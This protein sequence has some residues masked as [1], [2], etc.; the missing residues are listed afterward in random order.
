MG[1]VISV[2]AGTESQANSIVPLALI[3]QL[4][5][6][7]AIIPPSQMT[8]VMEAVSR[9]AASQWGLRGAGAAIDLQTSFNSFPSS[10]GSEGLT[11]GFFN[12]GLGLAVGALLAISL[13]Q[14]AVMAMR[15][16]K[17]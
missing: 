17:A 4:L 2:L 9:L 12:T 7:G 10:P 8:W 11:S 5:L 15:L 13:A 16:R 14:L 6:G 1:L 3:P